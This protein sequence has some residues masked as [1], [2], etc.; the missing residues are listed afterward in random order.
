MKKIKL[1]C[2]NISKY[3]SLEDLYYYHA[4]YEVSYWF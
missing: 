3:P 1:N 2:L 4:A